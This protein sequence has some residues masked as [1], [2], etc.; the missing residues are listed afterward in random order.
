MAVLAAADLLVV[1]SLI[2]E[3]LCE[4]ALRQ[5]LISSQAGTLQL[6]QLSEVFL[7]RIIPWSGS[8]HISDDLGK[9]KEPGKQNGASSQE[10]KNQIFNA[11]LL[12]Q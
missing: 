2:S 12:V 6:V 5:R 7:S 8:K 9:T 3:E 11:C 1:T 10:K 4:Q